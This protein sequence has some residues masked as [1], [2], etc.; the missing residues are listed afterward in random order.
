MEPI[1]NKISKKEES[2]YVNPTGRRIFD[3]KGIPLSFVDGKFIP[4]TEEEKEICEYFV[5]KNILYKQS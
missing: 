5:A 1:V 4:R 2:C 3:S